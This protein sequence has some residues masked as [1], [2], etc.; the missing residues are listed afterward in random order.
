MNSPRV[1]T[2]TYVVELAGLMR[3]NDELQ[4]LGGVRYLDVSLDL[5]FT[6][7]FGGSIEAGGSQN[8]VDPFVGLRARTPLSDRWVLNARAD[9]GGFRYRV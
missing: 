6:G 3:L 7:S 4:L 5:E 2:D 8:W 1:K 9:V